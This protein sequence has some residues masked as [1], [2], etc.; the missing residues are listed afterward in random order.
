MVFSDVLMGFVD[1]IPVVLFLIAAIILQRVL[2]N[3]MSK[4]A[5]ALFSAGT[6]VVFVAGFLKALYKILL[7]LRIVNWEV[8]SKM[9]FPSQTIGFVLAGAGIAALLFHKQGK[10]TAY[11]IALPALF[12]TLGYVGD[13]SNMEIWSGTMIFVVLMCLGVIVMDVGLMVFALKIKKPIILVLLIVSIIC[14]LAMGYLST[15]EEMNDWVK[16]IIN[17]LGQGSLLASAILFKKSGLEEQDIQLSL[18]K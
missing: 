12:V 6:I 13:Y 16:E 8:L 14:T 4:G 5:F 10:G 9:F 7:T 1:L 17:I 2:Y 11:C 15:K 18:V 3:K